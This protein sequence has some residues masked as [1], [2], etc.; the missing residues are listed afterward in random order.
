MIK[1]H[2]LIGDEILGPI[3]TLEGVRQIIIQH[4]ERFDGKGYPFGLRGEE[5]SVKSRI[6]SVV[7]T[8]DAMMTDR[9]YRKALSLYQIKEELKTN[10]GTQFDPYIVESFIEI[11]DKHGDQILGAAGYDAFHAMY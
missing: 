9:P 6:L 10:A 7:D 3:E 8:F 5:L 1:A 4:H 11:L 2:P